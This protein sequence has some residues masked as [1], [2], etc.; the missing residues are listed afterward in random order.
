MKKYFYLLSAIIL[1]ELIPTPGKAQVIILTVVGKGDEGYTG[2]NAKADTCMIHWPE[3]IAIDGANNMFIADANNNVIRK[4]NTTTGIIKT[5]VGSGFQHGTGLGGFSGD[6]GPA[7][8]ARMSYPSGIAVDAIGNMYIADQR[9]DRI[10][11]VD[12][13]GVITTYAG[14][15]FPGFSGDGGAA[16]SAKLYHPTRVTLDGTGN[17]YIADSGNNRIRKV[18]ATGNISTVAGNGVKGY[19]GDGGNA[20]LA[21]MANPIDMVVDAAGNLYIADYGNNRI[22]KVDAAGTMTT[23]AGISIP[24]FSGDGGPATA[25]NIYEPAGLAID[26]AGNLYFSDLANFRIRKIDPAGIIT[27]VAGNGLP[28]YNGDGISATSAQIWFPEGI[29]VDYHGQLF[30]CDKGNN[31]IRIITGVLDVNTFAA[32]SADMNLYPNPNSGNFTINITSPVS[33][34]VHIVI[35]SVTGQRMNDF[36]T[37]TNTPTSVSI[38][39]IPGLAPGMYLLSASTAHGVL[40]ERIIVQ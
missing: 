26:P 24:G 32:N 39:N 9:N 17:L 14:T 23:Y 34:D 25:A 21:E 11:K 2:D 12:T 22:R 33:E 3:A 4:V 1:A 29:A 7:T 20:L 36:V 19:L 15:G 30:V 6:S 16:I 40:N 35:A 5:V 8:A 13:F 37:L 28:G 18:D 27:T 10:R 38:G 31:R